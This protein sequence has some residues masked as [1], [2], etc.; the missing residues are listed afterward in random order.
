[1]EWNDLPFDVATITSVSSLKLN[2]SN[3]SNVSL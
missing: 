1:M 3:L 2:L